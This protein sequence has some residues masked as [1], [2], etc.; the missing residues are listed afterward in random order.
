MKDFIIR[1]ISIFIAVPTMATINLL[2]DGVFGETDPYAGEGVNY[3]T[4][5]LAEWYVI[6][7]FAFPVYLLLG[8]PVSYVVDYISKKL[9]KRFTVK[10]YLLKLTL[11]LVVCVV[12]ISLVTYREQLF[13][14]FPVHLIIVPVLTG[15]H[16]LYFLEKSFKNKRKTPSP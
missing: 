8:I 10:V 3:T 13:T 6:A 11:Y 4:S 15:F 14:L 16:A 1:L 2:I 7:T 12:L 9:N 5:P